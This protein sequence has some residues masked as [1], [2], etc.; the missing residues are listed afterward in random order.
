MLLRQLTYLV[1]L[2]QEQ[3]FGRA[4]EKCNVSQPTLS[5]AIRTLEQDLGISVVQRSRRFEGFTADGEKVLVWARRILADCGAL[6]QEA[7]NRE[8]DPAG[9][10]RLG[11]IP[12]VLSMVPLMT[13][14]CLSTYPRMAHEIYTLSTSQILQGISN[15]ELDI[16][17]TY[18]SDGRLQAF[19]TY[20]LFTER[21]VL[22]ARDD[23]G[24]RGKPAL[25]W[26][27]VGELPLCLLTR[28][29]QCRQGVDEAFATAGVQVIPRV[30][31]DSMMVLYGHVRCSGLYSVVP[32]S[33]LALSEMRQ[34]ITAI[35][36]VPQLHREIG[37]VLLQR[38]PQPLLLASALS[39]FTSLDLQSRVDAFLTC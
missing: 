29:M 31:T 7:S 38:D 17:M 28:N 24:L 11:A 6:R 35:P 23:T 25:T 16:G 2:S 10:L 34:E 27:E 26:R 18:L 21:Y 12:T 15:F 4:A 14:S 32:H 30:E 36:I 8:L 5:E 20:P 33:V 37:L 3:H 39:L 22:I 19:E 1:T 9:T 13:D